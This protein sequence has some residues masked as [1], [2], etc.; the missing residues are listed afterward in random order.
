MTEQQPGS[1]KIYTETVVWSAPE[2]HLK[3]APYQMAIVVLDAGGR[4][5]ARLLGDR[6]QIGDAV[7]FAEYRDGVPYFRKSA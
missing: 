3:D 4:I 5:T 7:T 2:A 6:V 1:G